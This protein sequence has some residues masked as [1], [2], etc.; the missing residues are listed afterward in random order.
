[1]KLIRNCVPSVPNGS[2]TPDLGA[3]ENSA[4]DSAVNL[5]VNGV[6]DSEHK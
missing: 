1:M 6:Y 4:S 2:K 5:A 3:I